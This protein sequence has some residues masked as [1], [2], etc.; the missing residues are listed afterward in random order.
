MQ[1]SVFYGIPAF[2]WHNDSMTN[3]RGT[4]T[5]MQKAFKLDLS[6]CKLSM[7]QRRAWAKRSAVLIYQ[8][9][10]EVQSFHGYVKTGIEQ[11]KC[12]HVETDMQMYWDMLNAARAHTR[13]IYLPPCWL[14]ILRVI[15]V[16]LTGIWF[17]VFFRE[18]TWRKPRFS[19]VNDGWNRYWQKER[20]YTAKRSILHCCEASNH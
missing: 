10:A 4:R 18:A 9:N 13:C 6:V 12:G 16:A 20:N 17:L 11:I 7:W 2:R 14:I 8:P 5:C 19:G 15:R 1:I 3:S